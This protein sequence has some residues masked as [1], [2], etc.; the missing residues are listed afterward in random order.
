MGILCSASSWT[1]INMDYF[2]AFERKTI[3]RLGEIV[4]RKGGK[5]LAQGDT[6]TAIVRLELRFKPAPAVVLRA[7]RGTAGAGNRRS[8]RR[9]NRTQLDVPVGVAPARRN[10]A[11]CAPG[12]SD[13]AGRE[14]PGRQ[15]TRS[16]PLRSS[17]LNT[18]A[19]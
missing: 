12:G 15:S 7:V 14:R 8:C 10:K 5:L 9:C 16:D 1:S 17:H 4:S 13:T 2:P 3:I 6:N 19:A 18:A 11:A